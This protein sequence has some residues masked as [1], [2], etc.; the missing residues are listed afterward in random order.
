MYCF[1][2]L[3]LTKFG[4][5]VANINCLQNFQVHHVPRLCEHMKAFKTLRVTS[6]NTGGVL[7]QV[8]CHCWITAILSQVCVY[9]FESQLRGHMLFDSFWKSLGCPESS[10]SG[11]TTTYRHACTPKITCLQSVSKKNALRFFEFSSKHSRFQSSL[12]LCHICYI[13][14]ITTKETG[15]RLMQF[16]GSYQEKSKFSHNAG[17]CFE[18]NSSVI[19]AKIL[20]CCKSEVFWTKWLPPQGQ[21]FEDIP[22]ES[23]QSTHF[24]EKSS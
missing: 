9:T 17:A 15:W 16:W 7:L 5:Q 4:C 2:V 18:H 24:S 6:W 22:A 12:F 23:N 19:L 8:L 20:Q 11:L 14:A 1:Q 3:L 13:N 21:I 10:T